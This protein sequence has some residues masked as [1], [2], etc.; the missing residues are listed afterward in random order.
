MTSSRPVPPT[1]PRAGP[2]SRRTLLATALPQAQAYPVQFLPLP[3]C[4]DGRRVP[5]GVL[6]ELHI[7]GEGVARGYHHRADLTAERF[8]DRPGMG[9]LY[10]TGDLVRILP[11]GLV[12]L[13]GRAG[14]YDQAHLDADFREFAG[15]TP[16]AYARALRFHE[17]PSVAEPA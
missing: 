10:A 2:P 4:P 17:A 16:S 6:G 3:P 7:G 1:D 5:V 13:A 9:R 12:E 14:Y 11:D 15:M 8:V